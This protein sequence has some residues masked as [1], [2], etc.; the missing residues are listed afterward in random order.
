MNTDQIVEEVYL[1]AYG[2]LPD[3]EEREIGRRLFAEKDMT[4]RRTRRRLLWALL[5]TPEFMFKD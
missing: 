3:T 2:R 4:R 1:L 5:N